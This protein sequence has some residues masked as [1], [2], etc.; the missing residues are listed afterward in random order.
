MGSI[1]YPPFFSMFAHAQLELPDLNL[2][3]LVT[4][5]VAHQL[6]Y[7]DNSSSPIYLC[8]DCHAHIAGHEAILSRTFQGRVNMT[9]KQGILLINVMYKVWISISGVGSSEC[10]KRPS[11]QS[12]TINR[13]IHYCCCY[14]QVMWKHSR[15]EISFS[16]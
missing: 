5:A 11:Q 8:I 12:Y 6:E 1:I 7:L 3:L 9:M 10:V 4:P 13:P 2:K 15:M 16:S 14:M